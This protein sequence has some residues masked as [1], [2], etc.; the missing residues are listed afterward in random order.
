[1]IGARGWRVLN[2]TDTHQERAP[3]PG[4]GHAAARAREQRA[5]VARFVR[6]CPA[7]TPACAS[8]MTREAGP[9]IAPLARD[10][11]G[12]SGAMLDRRPSPAAVRG[13]ACEAASRTSRCGARAGW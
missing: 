2:E 1:M 9:R 4:R 6:A 12:T 13:P 8:P 10:A 11:L 3:P 7:G 5:A